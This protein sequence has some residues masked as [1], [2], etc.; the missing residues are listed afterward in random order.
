MRTHFQGSTYTVEFDEQDTEHFVRSTDAD[1]EEV[2]GHGAFI[3]DSVSGDLI[4]AKGAGAGRQESMQ[5]LAFSQDAQEHA[6]NE[7]SRHGVVVNPYDFAAEMPELH[8]PASARKGKGGMPEV[9]RTIVMQNPGAC[10]VCAMAGEE[11]RI[12]NIDEEGTIHVAWSGGGL[13][14]LAPDDD[15]VMPAA[16]N[17]KDITRTRGAKTM[18]GPYTAKKG[19]KP[20]ITRRGKLGEG[21]LTTMTKKQRE[22][23]LDNCVKGY[24]Y[25]SCLGSIQALER[26]KTGPRGTGKGVGVKYAGKLKASRDYLRET[27]GGKGARKREE[28]RKK[29][30]AP[31]RKAAET[32]PGYDVN[33]AAEEHKRRAYDYLREG[34][35]AARRANEHYRRA[36]A[37]G[38]ERTTVG[39]E[40]DAACNYARD[41]DRFAMLASHEIDTSGVSGSEGNEFREMVESLKLVATSMLN[42]LKCTW[43]T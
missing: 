43:Q 41:V 1:P 39:A 40:V 42:E 34:E 32:G 18:R 33:P 37:G 4:K 27:Y 15:V 26:A 35:A 28:E 24:G 31:A 8:N 9:G 30:K 13:S 23:A 3:F 10:P 12:T 6:R 11:G 17:P 14:P 38:L 22:K 29:K 19:Y 36:K 16:W 2:F 21:F 5:W 7:L 25:F 20:W